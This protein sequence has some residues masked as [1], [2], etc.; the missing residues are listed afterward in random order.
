MTKQKTEKE[1][2]P[3]K[4]FLIVHEEMVANFKIWNYLQCYNVLT[5]K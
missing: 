4:Y 3:E 5:M 1:N 2:G